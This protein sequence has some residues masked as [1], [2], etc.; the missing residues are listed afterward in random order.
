MLFR[1]CAAC[2]AS[3]GGVSTVAVTAPELSRPVTLRVS[4]QSA[5]PV[6]QALVRIRFGDEAGSAA[7]AAEALSREETAYIVGVSGVPRQW[8][9][10]DP[11]AL[12]K[13]AFLRIKGLP[14]RQPAEVRAAA[15]GEHVNL[16]LLFPK[17][18]G[19]GRPIAVEDREVEVSLKFTTT[20]FS[21]K[22]KLKEMV[23]QGRLEL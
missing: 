12:E 11:S 10:A 13:G 19:G 7:A 23:Y 1:S 2:E 20:G 21:R 8:I 4:W 14:P 6:K 3:G 16:L 17:Q 18:Q 5:L 15:E 9:P 22:F